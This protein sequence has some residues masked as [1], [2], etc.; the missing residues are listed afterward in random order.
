MAPIVLAPLTWRLK[1]FIGTP[2]NVDGVVTPIP[3]AITWLSTHLQFWKVALAATA[4]CVYFR[5]TSSNGGGSPVRQ[6]MD[7][8]QS[9]P[10]ATMTATGPACRFTSSPSSAPGCGM[11]FLM[12]FQYS[13]ICLLVKK[14]PLAMTGTLTASHSLTI[15]SQ[16][17]GSA[18][19]SS[20]LRM[21]TVIASA[22]EASHMRMKSRVFSVDDN[23]RILQVSEQLEGRFRRSVFRMSQATSGFSSSAAPIPP[24]TLKDFGQP[25]L[26]SKPRTSRHTVRAASEAKAALAVPSWKINLGFS[27]GFVLKTQTRSRGDT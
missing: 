2:P 1:V 26:M 15:S 20:R 6:N 13:S 4:A 24:L 22:P 8:F 9:A 25:M 17:A 10:L 21:C 18:G 7:G 27:S 12:C 3:P 14:S 5:T 11:A 23:I 16:C 19:R